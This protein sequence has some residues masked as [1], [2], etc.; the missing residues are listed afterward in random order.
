MQYSMVM[1]LLEHFGLPA[2]QGGQSSGGQVSPAWLPPQPYV[3]EQPQTPHSSRRT[4]LSV[5]PAC[6]SRSEKQPWPSGG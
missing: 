6:G 3:P 5:P 1:L 4:P 2:G